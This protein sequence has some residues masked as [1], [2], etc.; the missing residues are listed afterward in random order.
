MQAKNATH[1]RKS[2]RHTKPRT[3]SNLI[4]AS[5]GN[6]CVNF[7]TRVSW[8]LHVIRPGLRRRKRK[9]GTGQLR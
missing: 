2:L 1:S 6:D 8:W 5:L 7:N 3:Q 4:R 9:A